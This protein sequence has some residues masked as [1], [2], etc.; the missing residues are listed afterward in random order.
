MRYVFG[1]VC[2]DGAARSVSRAVGTVHLTTKAFDLLVLLLDSRPNVVSKEQI[3]ERL[4]PAT[5]VTESSI[6]TLIHE[7]RDAIDDP[8]DP[9]SWIRTVRGVGYCFRADASASRWPTA[10]RIGHPAAWLVGDSMRVALHAGE[11]IV[12]RAGVGIVEIDS[13]TISRRHARITI[14]DSPVL[15]DLGSKNGTWLDGER[16][17]EPRALPDGAIV[18]LGSV[19]FTFRLD[20]PPTPTESVDDD[21]P[22]AGTDRRHPENGR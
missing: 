11:N 4:W 7:I 19:T 12:G 8:S 6:Q 9:N 2:V 13:P 20:R 14:G 3:H 16:L 18:R 10:N 1:G 15:D 5:F 17:M 22:P 21:V